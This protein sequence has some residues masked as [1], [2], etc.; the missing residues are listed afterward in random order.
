MH[1]NKLERWEKIIFIVLCLLALFTRL[2]MLGDRVMSHDESLHTKYSWNL[3]AGQGYQHNPMMHGPLLFHVTAL[4]YFL[5]GV[6]DFVSRLLPALAGMVLVLS[7][8]L[9][10]RWLGRW[11]TI[12][13]SLMLLLSPSISYY[14]RYIRHDTFNMLMSVLLLWTVFNYLEKQEDRWLYKLGAFFSLLYTT[15]ETSYIY[16]VIFVILLS[17]LFVQQAFAL[18]WTRPHLYR[19]FLGVLILALLLGAAFGASLV[20]AEMEE[21]A[22]DEAGNTRAATLTL[23]LWG[24]LVAGLALIALLSAIGIGYLGVGETTLRTLPLFDLLMAIG[25]LTLPLGSAIFIRLAGVDM[26]KLYNAIIN[27]DMNALMGLDILIIGVV[28]LFFLGGSALLGLWWDS[29]RWP[30]IAAIHYGIFLVLFT[31]VFTN[32]WGL[33]SGMLGALAYWMAQHGVQRGGQPDYYYLL[34]MS[35]YEYLPFLFSIGII[36]YATIRSL[37]RSLKSLLR[38]LF[39]LLPGDGG[40]DTVVKALK[41]LLKSILDAFLTPPTD[42]KVPTLEVKA[43]YPWFLAGWTL[44]AWLAYT[45]A[46]EKMPWLTVHIALPSIFLAAWGLG[47]VIDSLSQMPLLKKNG[48]WVLAALPLTVIGWVI[49]TAALGNLITQVRAGVSPAGLSLTQ[50][51]LLGQTLGGLIGFAASFAALLWATSQAGPQQALRLVVLTLGAFLALL[52]V[53]TMTMLN[54]INYDMA[55]ELLVYAHGAPDV[56]VALQQ[57][58]DISWRTT[59]AE[60]DVKVAYSEDGSWPFAWY[61]VDY[62]NNYFYGTTPDATALL[63]S[64]VIIAGQPQW[65]VVETIVGDSY[66]HFDYKYLWWPIQDYYD[67]TWERVR[68]A[69]TDPAMRSALWDIIW[70][71]DYSRFAE[72]TGKSITLKEWPYRKEFRLYVR[73]DLASEVWG[74]RLGE[75]GG[76][77]Q[78]VTPIVTPI[79]DPYTSVIKTLPMAATIT[80]PS[81]MPRGIAAAEDGTL[82]LAD[83]LNHRIWHVNQQGAVLDSWGE[84]GSGSGQFQEPWGIAIDDEGNIYIADTWNHRVQKFDAQGEFLLS[85]GTFG[86]YALGDPNGQGAFF[87]PRALAVG[88]GDHIYVVDTGNK[89]VQVFDT[90]GDF[91][92]E[93]GGSGRNPGQFNE[94]VGI[95]IN[96]KGE[97]FIADSW[98]Y[99][100][101][102]LTTLGDPLHQWSIPVWDTTNPEE[103]PYLAL[104]KQSRVYLSDSGHNRVLAF[105]TDGTFL[106][107]AG[108]TEDTGTPLQFPVGVA[109]SSNGRLYV[110]D[111][112]TGRTVGFI[113]P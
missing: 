29:R 37:I 106:W 105:G 21:Q 107:S 113:L 62:P 11:G 41:S 77:A 39:S 90:T 96:A 50:L 78:V 66:L 10:R 12:M 15:K 7:P 103:K 61:M 32:A 101:Q 72:A 2:Y 91:L 17:L 60:H 30:I 45:V 85:W 20:G 59:G 67:M 99:R 70:D 108:Q 1:W 19:V 49:F 33:L 63:E 89:R 47:R 55:T 23:P 36:A 43:F 34:T 22:L 109:V 79:V 52:T 27:S 97:V 74:Y 28:L 104:D 75:S 102:V 3:Y 24:K 94:P 54:F 56:K 82:Y 44:L 25:T 42:E 73:R 71:R 98:N 95:A 46:G 13:A 93:F 84:Q 81:A 51:T 69:I 64:P 111:A 65:D 112:H 80:L 35:L 58:D 4:A 5:F 100:V 68:S 8:W 110:S 6:N 53:R 18:R 88:P 9:F 83:T 31:T 48:W 57:I 16:T 86:Q 76:T 92:Y 38:R 26:L 40:I 87:G 14:A